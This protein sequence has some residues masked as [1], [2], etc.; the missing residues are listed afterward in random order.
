MATVRV[1]SRR[2]LSKDTFVLRTER[3]NTEIV[4]GQCFSIGTRHLAINREY[5][6]YSR[7]KD[8]FVDFLIRK[9]EGGEV[10]SELSEL[11]ENDS[12]E[13]SGPYG[14]FCL[15]QEDVDKK[16]FIFIASGTGIAPFHSFALTYPKLKYKLLH[17]IR[18]ENEMY[19]SEDYLD[20]SYI[21]AISRPVTGEATRVTDLLRDMHISENELIYLCGNRN[22]IVDSLEI[23]RSK[24][25]E[26]S[27]IYM[28]TF[29]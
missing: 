17:G 13:I 16:R 19:D 3:P 28:E 21:S 27:K 22:M 18:F 24:G 20:E 1:I 26:G 15:N 2:D 9:V 14:K 23:L 7:A 5:S 12:V 25:V 29:F 8:P 4:A 6:M 10:S 11:T